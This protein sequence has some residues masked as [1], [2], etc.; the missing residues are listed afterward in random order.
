M[1]EDWTVQH[2]VGSFFGLTPKEIDALLEDALS[3]DEPQAVSEKLVE[4]C[5]QC[6]REKDIG[7]KCW[8]CGC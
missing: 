7:T 4:G 3:A 8:W 6:G 5:N 1:S 2:E